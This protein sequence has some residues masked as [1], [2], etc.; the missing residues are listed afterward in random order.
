MINTTIGEFYSFVK[1]NN[2]D[3]LSENITVQSSKDTFQKIEAV[4]ITLKD[5]KPY[6]IQT[7]NGYTLLCGK[8]HLLWKNKGLWYPANKLTLSD[9]VLTD[10]GFQKI[11]LIKKSKEILENFYDLQVANTQSYFTNGILSHNSTI[12]KTIGLGLWGT[13]PNIYQADI[14]N[15]FNKNGEILVEFNS[16][17]NNHVKIHRKFD[18]SSLKLIVDGEDLTSAK[19]KS[20]QKYIESKLLEMD[21]NVFTN[22]IS[23]S[24]DDFKS[25]LTMSPD[26]KRKIIDKVLSLSV[27]NKIHEDV[28]KSIK[29]LDTK[30]TLSKNNL[31]SIDKN[32]SR[33]NRDIEDLKLKMKE[34]ANSEEKEFLEQLERSQKE[35]S[36]LEKDY[37][38]YAKRKTK[39]MTIDRNLSS[40]YDSLNYDIKTIT[41]SYSL[42]SENKCPTCETDLTTENHVHKKNELLL[43]LESTQSK[44]N[45]YKERLS[46]LQ[47][48]YKE[49][50]SKE[51]TLNG[52][53]RNL[54][55]SIGEVN[56][57]LSKLKENETKDSSISIS[58]FEKIV[59]DYSA[60][61]KEENVS[62]SKNSKNSKFLAVVKAVVSEDGI[63]SVVLSTIVPS[64]NRNINNYLQY[65]NNINFNVEFDLNFNSKLTQY[66]KEINNGTL[67]SGESKIL[68]FCVLLSIVK[69]IKTKYIN[70]NI[71]FLDE[72]FASLDANNTNTVIKILRD[73]SKE[74]RLNIFTIHHAPLQRSLF[75]NYITIVKTN[76]FSDLVFE[77]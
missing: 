15:R 73:F 23:L 25:F 34:K 52:K 66:G 59:E 11:I 62:L 57:N 46:K 49:T 14:S 22:I 50:T 75:D 6:M 60:Q 9:Y 56:R 16:I 44:F 40:I 10:E 13:N 35:L 71:L 64:L 74:E 7:A 29:T 31:D 5:S 1:E 37:A 8:D 51:S 4:D 28:K 24:L 72:I 3:L 54:E 33:I 21:L 19:K 61:H 20:V 77:E 53:I 39:I 30:M 68:D 67:S 27:F 58:K 42:Y 41:K 17:S 76:D 26:E 43:K 36:L 65:F 70:L 18:P 2:I 38:Y 45:I 47:D 63:K 32:I 69:L 55:Y 48:T 12:A